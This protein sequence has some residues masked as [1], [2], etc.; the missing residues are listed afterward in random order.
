MRSKVRRPWMIALVGVTAIVAARP[1]PAS[2]DTG[3]IDALKK[4][5]FEELMNL[6]V[7][8]VSRKPEKL[9]EAASAVQV[10]TAEDIRR[11]GAV[12]IVD[13]LRLA[14]NLQVAQVNASQ[15]AV[16]ARGFNNVLANKLL[17]RVRR[18]FLHS[19][20]FHVSL[21]TVHRQLPK[22]PCLRNF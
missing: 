2:A 12:S 14:P 21:L 5:S 18:K 10:I 9:S 13:A 15:W 7:T 22:S 19:R 4:L 1:H 6:E 17:L 16:S 8:T 3:S 11:S 20:Q